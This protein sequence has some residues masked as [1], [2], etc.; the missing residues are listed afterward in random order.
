LLNVVLGRN[1]STP[2]TK[3]D[4]QKGRTCRKVIS[5]PF[6]P[7]TTMVRSL[8]Y[9]PW[10][11]Q[12]VRCRQR[13]SSQV[14]DAAPTTLHSAVE[15]LEAVE[16][17]E[18]CLHYQAIFALPEL[19]LSGFEALIRW[20]HPRRGLLSPAEFLPADMDGGLGWALTNF[21]LEEAVR[22]CAEWHRSGVD[23]GVSVNIPPGRLADE[24]L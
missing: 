19:R 16:R 22:S 14:T 23:A 15:L 7:L 21:A 8:Y 13:G 12:C 4:H 2:Q 24:V 10:V 5:S 11:T 20:Q 18:L 9:S 6:G 17:G 3:R 1:R